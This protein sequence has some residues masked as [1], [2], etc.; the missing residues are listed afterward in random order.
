[1]TNVTT[2]LRGEML[3]LADADGRLI[4]VQ[5]GRLWITQ[6]GEGADHI[7]EAG[8]TFTIG[9][10]GVTLVAALRP[11]AFQYLGEAVS[12]PLQLAAA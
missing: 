3:R 11:S 1:M 4:R 2:M 5:A 7:V 6:E 12:L 10:P 8:Q 9:K